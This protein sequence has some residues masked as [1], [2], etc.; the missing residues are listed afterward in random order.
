MS[1]NEQLAEAI[2]EALQRSP[3][4]LNF[5][6]LREASAGQPAEEAD[7]RQTLLGLLESGEAHR[8]PPFRGKECY[9]S[10][11][12]EEQAREGV[13]NAL[14][15]GSV[16]MAELCKSA[17][18]FLPGCGATHA[19]K[20]VKEACHALLFEGRI[21]RHPRAGRRRERFGLTPADP[22]AYLKDVQKAIQA[23]VDKLGKVGVSPEAVHAAIGELLNLPVTPEAEPIEQLAERIYQTIRVVEP[24]APL[25][26]MATVERLRGRLE[27]PAGSR[28]AFDRAVLL[29]ARN[30]KVD[31]HKMYM[32]ESSMTEKERQVLVRDEEGNYY[33]GVT[34][35]GESV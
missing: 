33:V 15:G 21:F 17:R 30:G 27:P 2:Q 29:L 25:G 22:R 13:L 23:V 9:W 35:R 5:E 10:R 26:A 34:L 4:P 24:S 16:T 14:A 31:L 18:K 11:A 19:D 32:P 6:R 28:E 1:N 12:V 7:F 3:A 8:W 20:A